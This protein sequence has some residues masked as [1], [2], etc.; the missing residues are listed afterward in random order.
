MPKPVIPIEK[1][2]TPELLPVVQY[3]IEGYLVELGNELGKLPMV[4][5]YGSG[6]STPWFAEMSWVHSLE[7]DKE[8]YA[9]VKKSLRGKKGKY[10]LYQLDLENWNKFLSQRP[11]DD[12]PDLYDLILIDCHSDYRNAAVEHAI[13]H[14]KVG[15]WF[16]LEDAHW[17]QLSRARKILSKWPCTVI[18][19]QYLRKSGK[20]AQAQTNIYQRPE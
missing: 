6:H 15:G 9:E 7:H 14:M 1:P 5:E 19:G 10:Q 16:V 20:I 11:E 8:W 3:A 13:P 2:Y 12:A 17:K 18:S 4:L